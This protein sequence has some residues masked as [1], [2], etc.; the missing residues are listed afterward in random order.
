MTPSIWIFK[1]N[2]ADNGWYSRL[3]D[4]K[5]NILI[6]ISAVK[7]D[8]CLNTLWFQPHTSWDSG[9]CRVQWFSHICRPRL[10]YIRIIWL[11]LVDPGGKCTLVVCLSDPV[12]DHLDFCLQ[13][14]VHSE[15]APLH[16]LKKYATIMYILTMNKLHKT[17]FLKR[18]STS[19]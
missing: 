11:R 12:S 18:K 8:Q 2:L 16:D 7:T 6:N 5:K 19:K 10:V 1:R 3:L 9:W 13:W 15:I 17:L 14:W 4:E